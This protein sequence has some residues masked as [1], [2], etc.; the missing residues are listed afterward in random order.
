MK[1]FISEADRQN[2]K[3]IAL[4]NI[5]KFYGI[6]DWQNDDNVKLEKKVLAHTNPLNAPLQEYFAAY[7][8]WFNFYMG[9]KQKEEKSKEEHELDDKEREKL[10]GLIQKLINYWEKLPF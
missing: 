10:S 7:D 5:A 3:R 8:A 1:V 6:P 9:I 4:V 2:A